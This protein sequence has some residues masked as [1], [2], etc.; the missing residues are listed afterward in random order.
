MGIKL[1]TRFIKQHFNGLFRPVKL[2]QWRSIVVDGNG[3]CHHLYYTNHC[4][5]QLGGEYPEFYSTTESYFDLIRTAGV[6]PVVIFD[7]SHDQGKTETVLKRKEDK[8]RAMLKS[9]ETGY[10]SRSSVSPILMLQTFMDV[11][12]GMKIEFHIAPSEGD[13]EVAAVANSRGC[14]VLSSDSDFFMYDLEHGFIPLEHLNPVDSSFLYHIDNFAAYFG[15]KDPKLRLFLPALHGNDFISP[16]A[17]YRT[18]MKFMITIKRVSKYSS[19][20]ECLDKEYGSIVRKNY[21]AAESQ[22]CSPHLSD[23]ESQKASYVSLYSLPEWT[24]DSFLSGSFH[25]HLLDILQHKVCTLGNVVEDIHQQSAWICSRHI[26]QN[27]YGFIGL[28]EEVNEN[29]R[30][31]RSP[32]MVKTSIV[33]KNTNPP[34]HLTEFQEKDKEGIVLAILGCASAARNL[35]QFHE[36]DEKWKLPLATVRYWFHNSELV[37]EDL[38]KALLLCFL[39]CSGVQVC[40]RLVDVP[41]QSNFLA[42]HVFAQ[43]QCV[44]YDAMVLNNITRTPLLTTSPSEL[45]SGKVAMFFASS[46]AL[47]TKESIFQIML[48]FVTYRGI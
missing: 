13:K 44:Y 33:I 23:Y 9:Q 14:P 37:T 24:F 8:N 12:Q 4:D 7:G 45:F 47:T 10:P 5:W 41:K 34:A 27:I 3:L 46:K 17:D 26:R 36:L 18:G 11:L 28:A 16:R 1:F 42:L 31:D 48:D 30:R 6:E 25:P 15:L 32:S 40:S 2:S 35:K 19:S 21:G 38:L 22:Y 43:W 20:E 39:H 29:I